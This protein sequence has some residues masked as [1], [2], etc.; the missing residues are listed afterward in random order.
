[1]AT[2]VF[3]LGLAVLL[4]VPGAQRPAPLVA[5]AMEQ[6]TVPPVPNVSITRITEPIILDGVSDEPVW[7]TIDPLPLTMR[8]PL[9]HGELTERTEIRIAHDESYLYVCGRFYD[10]DPSGI[11]VNSMYRDQS[12]GDDIFGLLVNPYDDNDIGL[13]FWT[14]P[15]GVRIDVEV[16]A[17]AQAGFNGNWNTYWDVATRQTDEGWFAEMRIPF[18]SLGFQASAGQVPIAFTTYRY[19]AR[20]NERQIFPDIAPEYDFFRASLAYSTVLEGIQSHRPVYITPYVLGGAAQRNELN[21]AATEFQMQTDEEAE[22]GLDLKYNVTD[23]LTLDL[24]INTDFAQVEAD[25]Q[26]INLTR[27]PLFF[28]EKRQFFLERSGTFAF[29]TGGST[30]LFHSRRIGLVSGEPVRIFGGVRLVGR[31][32]QWDVGV[33]NIQTAKTDALAS[34][35]FGVAR[36]RRR[37]INENSNAGAILTT[38]ITT[39]GGYNV[40]YGLD[41]RIHLFGDDYL[42]LQWVQ[43]LDDGIIDAQ[44]FRFVES[45]LARFTYYRA[46]NRGFTYWFQ[47]RYQGEDYLPGMGFIGRQNFS[48]FFYSLAYFH[49]PEGEGP[50]RRIDPFQLFGSVALRNNDGSVESAFIE[51]D[52]DL[53]W[54]SGA[55]LGLD[56]ELYYDDLRD[57]L[58]FPSESRVPI[59]SYWYPRFEFDYNMPPGDLLRASVGGGIQKFY[60]GWR[61]NVWAGP[62]WNISRHFGLNAQYGFDYVRFPDRD[63]G[64]D[65]HLLR[66]RSNFA[67]NTKLSVNAFVQLS[68]TRHLMAANVRLRYNF[69]EGN[70]LWIVYSE[71][72][73]LDLDRVSPTLPRTDSRTVLVKYTHTLAR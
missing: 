55:S 56:L 54:R 26:Q 31:V 29:N 46:R 59:G 35:N 68:N 17:D 22:A 50:F 28:P 14:T 19:I 72:W 51:H 11:R 65:S 49:Y 7:R 9:H 60:D 64:F 43:T 8:E 27:Y 73:N 48:D 42:T 53:Q 15:A 18:T 23:N 44:G 63:Q 36:V 37:V 62:L 38:R 5:Q 32:G 24:T 66:L 67:L 2:S 16:P 40:G 61:W 6:D 4:V 71:G 33:L 1:M 70:D 10:S 52:F 3:R 13:V 69:R 34:E 57:P 21:A 58:D 39:D 25:D 41:S 47:G 20:K 30:R 45:G 12:R